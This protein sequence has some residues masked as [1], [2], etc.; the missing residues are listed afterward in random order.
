[1]ISE[2]RNR[3]EDDFHRQLTLARRRSSPLRCRLLLTR[4]YS[5]SARLP[6]SVSKSTQASIRYSG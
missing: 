5:R 2:G 1:M 4:V 3:T 6:Y